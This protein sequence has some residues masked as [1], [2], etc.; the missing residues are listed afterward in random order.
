MLR[1]GEREREGEGGGICRVVELGLIP[2]LGEGVCTKKSYSAGLYLCMCGYTY[3]ESRMKW[4]RMATCCV[5]VVRLVVGIP[6]YLPM[7]VTLF[8]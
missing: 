6:Q 4:N 3:G 7:S 2:P 5:A 8:F 1:L